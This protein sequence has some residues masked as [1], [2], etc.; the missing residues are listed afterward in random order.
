M[1]R[2]SWFQKY[3]IR[4]YEGCHEDDALHLCLAATVKSVFFIPDALYHYNIGNQNSLMN[5]T[6]QKEEYVSAL[7]Y[8]FIYLKEQN[9]YAKN[10]DKIRNFTTNILIRLLRNEYY[11]TKL[12][13]KVIEFWKEFFPGTCFRTSVL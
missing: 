2:R 7:R 1:Y 6:R 13:N 5:S 3:N 10:I 4:M 12:L 9:L 11:E 8:A